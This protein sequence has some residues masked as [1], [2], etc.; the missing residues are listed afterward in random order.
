MT[1]K[2]TNDGKKVKVIGKLN[3][4]ETIVQ[5]IY[6]SENSEIP[7]GEQFVVK[8]LHDEPVISWKEK[9]AIK[10]EDRVTYLQDLHK[11]LLDDLH[12]R[13]EKVLKALKEKIKQLELLEKNITP[14]AFEMLSKFISGKYKFV[15]INNR[16]SE[17]KME[18]QVST[19]WNNNFD[20]LKLV[21][22][23]GKSNGDLQYRIHNY[24]DGSGTTTKLNLFETLDEAKQF[25]LDRHKNTPYNDNIIE[26]YNKW[27]IELNKEK[28][29]AY[30]QAKYDTADSNVI[31]LK[32]AY[33][34]ALKE[35]DKYAN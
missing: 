3:S 9:E 23:F 2:Y 1:I 32:E 29:K 6:V 24:Y 22:L 12:N 33:L 11:K 31:K 4:Q 5:E 28:M 10:L 34:K 15:V 26:E 27:G 25:L 30:T 16:I 19:T 20:G 14:K 35:R 21:S 13:E 17:F 18:E 8:T 7:S